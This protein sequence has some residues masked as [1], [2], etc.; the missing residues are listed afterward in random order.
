MQVRRFGNHALDIFQKRGI[1]LLIGL[2]PIFLTEVG[3]LSYDQA[4]VVYGVFI[5][6]LLSSIDMLLE[7]S[8]GDKGGEN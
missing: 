7:E 6:T 3:V 8:L 2:F 4:M 1:L 5:I